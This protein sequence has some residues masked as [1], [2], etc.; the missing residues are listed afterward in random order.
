MKQCRLFREHLLIQR[1]LF[2][3]S[4]YP[5]DSI[6]FVYG[7]LSCEIIITTRVGKNVIGGIF[8]QIV[9]KKGLPAHPHNVNIV[10][11]PWDSSTPTHLF[12]KLLSINSH[13]RSIDVYRNPC[14]PFPTHT[15]TLPIFFHFVK[16]EKIFLHFFILSST[17][18][19][20]FRYFFCPL[21]SSLG[22]AIYM[23]PILLLFVLCFL[24]VCNIHATHF[25]II[26]IMFPW[27]MQYTC[28]PF[29]YYLYYVSLGYAIYMVPILLLFVLCFLGVC[30]I[31]A[32]HFVIICIMFPW[33]MQYTC[34]PFCYYLYYVSLGYA[35]YMV[36]ILLLFVLYPFL[37]PIYYLYYVSL[38]Y[39][40][41]MVP[42]LL[43]FVLCTCYP[44]CYYLY[45]VSLGYAIYMVPLG[46]C[47]IHG[48][49]FV[50][51]C[52]MFPWGMQYTW[53]PFCYY[54]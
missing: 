27:G 43:L 20:Q 2:I 14:C 39:A 24:G 21:F 53:Y 37:L 30:N 9:V 13:K 41:Y 50:I 7:K 54:L 33:G 25:V 51:I 1:V 17:A 3:C 48:T 38:G 8:L 12:D 23:V 29:C 4:R 49:H 22:Y 46:V 40:I 35:I 52:I 16:E 6:E 18:Q 15:C 47:N 19:H 26:C 44:F 28:Y 11:F 45:Y 36:P 42:I 32:T 31:H 34:Y 5:V 10:F